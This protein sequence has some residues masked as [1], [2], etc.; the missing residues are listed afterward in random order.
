MVPASSHCRERNVVAATLPC[1]IETPL[2]DREVRRTVDSG[3][4]RLDKV[5]VVETALVE[6]V[7]QIHVHRDVV[8]LR[9]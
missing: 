8:L 2:R 7:K 5:S 4:R 1:D 3:R 6:T 9:V